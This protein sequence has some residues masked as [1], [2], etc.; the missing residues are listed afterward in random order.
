M[1]R[2]KATGMFSIDP[3]VKVDHAKL[4]RARRDRRLTQRD[5]EKACGIENNVL[6]VYELGKHYPTLREIE[7]L[8]KHYDV[9]LTS[10]L[11]EDS[12]RELTK[13]N[14]LIGQLIGV[15]LLPRTKAPSGS[16]DGALSP[17]E[18][19]LAALLNFVRETARL[20]ADTERRLNML[21][22]VVE[23]YITK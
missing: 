14:N 13:L 22:Q 21:V 20:Q 23:T 4:R 2:Q 12:L 15:E 7:R 8:S 3:R 1:G 6:T 17:L 19:S 9:P 11:A 10:L 18:G 5:V 16:D